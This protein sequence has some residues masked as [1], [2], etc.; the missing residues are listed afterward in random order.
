MK[1]EKGKDVYLQA[2]TMIDPATGWIEIYFEP[3]VRADLVTYQVEVL[4]STRFTLPDKIR[5]DRC[6]ELLAEANDYGILYNSIT[7]TN[8]QA[9]TIAQKVLQTVGNII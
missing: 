3:E 8:L 4:W 2:I 7:V 9:N 6:K 1:G 5:I